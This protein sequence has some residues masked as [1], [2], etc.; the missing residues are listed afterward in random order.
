VGVEVGVAVAV[1]VVV[2]VAVTVAVAVVVA[3]DVSVAVAVAVKVAVTD[4]VAVAVAVALAVGVDVATAVALAV[5]VAVPVAVGTGVNVGVPVAVAVS[6]GPGVEVLVTVGTGVNVDVAVGTP[7]LVGIAVA[8]ALATETMTSCGGFVPSRE[9]KSTPSVD[10]ATS[11]KQTGPLPAT[12]AVTLYSSQTPAVILPLSSCGLV[13]DGL[14]AQVMAVSAHVVL[15]QE[16]AGGPLAV[17]SR[18]QSLR[19]ARCIWPPT[20]LTVKRRY[21]SRTGLWSTSSVG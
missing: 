18:T 14:F 10:C 11:P 2:A 6:V 12:S 4:G 8:V 13:T 15:E 3:V 21:D 9:L 7:V 5:G 1:G 20:P 17:A 19:V 16:Y